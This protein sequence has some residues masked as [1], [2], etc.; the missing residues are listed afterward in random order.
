MT[1]K[2][3]PIL[4]PETLVEVIKICSKTGVSQRKKIMTYKE[5][6]AIKNNKGFYYR[7]YQIGYSS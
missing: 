4:S 3:N 5:S 7:I 2:Y 1:K 6:L